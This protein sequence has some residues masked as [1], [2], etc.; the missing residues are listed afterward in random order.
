M[1]A[2]TLWLSLFILGLTGARPHLN[3]A[4]GTALWRIQ[5]QNAIVD[6]PIISGESI[7]FAT[8]ADTIYVVSTAGAIVSSKAIGGVIYSSPL[9][10]GDTILVAPTGFTSLLV[11]LTLDK[12]QQWTQKWTFTPAK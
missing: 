9:Q 11:A 10:A 7:L 1:N 12:N 6:T 4:D 8:E 3:A 5:P 2:R